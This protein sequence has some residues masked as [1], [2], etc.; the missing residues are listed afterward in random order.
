MIYS[1]LVKDKKSNFFSS[2][3]LESA[4]EYLF[5]NLLLYGILLVFYAVLR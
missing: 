4:W 2:F 1:Y 5:V 3:S